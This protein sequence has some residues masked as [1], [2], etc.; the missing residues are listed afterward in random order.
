M[1]DKLK[2]IALFDLYGDL[3][4]EKQRNYF[5]E[6]YFDDLSLSEMAEN[7]GISRNAVHKQIKDALHKLE[8]Y[9]DILHLSLKKQKICAI[10]DKI[11]DKKIK[12]E[13]KELL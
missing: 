5:A 7:Y 11:K 3:L 6:S 13:L 12:E 4:T 9:E 8:W 2:Y 1:E 10:I